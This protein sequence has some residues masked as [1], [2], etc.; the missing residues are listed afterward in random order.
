MDLLIILIVGIIGFIAGAAYVKKKEV[1]WGDVLKG[2]RKIKDNN[3]KIL[4]R[5]TGEI[6]G[7]IP[8]KGE[9]PYT[10]Q[11]FDEKRW[12]FKYYNLR[13]KVESEPRDVYNKKRG[14][15]EDIV[16]IEFDGG[17]ALTELNNPDKTLS[18]IITGSQANNLKEQ[19]DQSQAIRRELGRI[20]NKLNQKDKRNRKLVNKVNNLSQEKEELEED[21]E[22]FRTTNERLRKQYESWRQMAIGA[23]AEIEQME[24]ELREIRDSRDEFAELIQPIIKSAKEVRKAMYTNPKTEGGEVEGEAAGMKMAPEDM[25]VEEEA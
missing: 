4:T 3:A 13:G 2:L 23:K 11:R 14:E 15:P 10:D 1:K 16:P 9:K 18:T 7:L 8:P 25:E 6:A 21:M 12:K 24:K 22:N 20:Q 19:I 17:I 5:P